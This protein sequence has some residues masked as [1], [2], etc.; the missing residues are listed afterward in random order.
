MIFIRK[1]FL[2]Y[3]R[4]FHTGKVSN[5]SPSWFS[6]KSIENYKGQSDKEPI[7]V[8]S[9]HNSWITLTPEKRN[10][11]KALEKKKIVILGFF[12]LNFNNYSLK[13]LN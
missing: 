13:F 8:F 2:N 12:N 5:D 4:E 3:I 7:F 10:R 11:N 6:N 9:K 1:L